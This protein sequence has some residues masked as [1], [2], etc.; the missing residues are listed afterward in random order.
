MKK[1]L[2]VMTAYE[3]IQQAI[4]KGIQ[5]ALFVLISEYCDFLL[6]PYLVAGAV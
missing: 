1:L 2:A 5:L 6:F 4:D 3:V